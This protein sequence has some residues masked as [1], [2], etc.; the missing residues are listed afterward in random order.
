MLRRLV[1]VSAFAALALPGTAAA[2]D[3][4]SICERAQHPRVGAW[5]E[6]KMIGG[7]NDGGTMRMSVVGSE[8]RGGTEYYWLEMVMRGFFNGRGEEASGPQRMISKMLVAGLGP[9]MG[10]PMATVVKVGDAP[11]MEMP[12]GRPSP[13]AQTHTGLEDCRDAKV[14]GWERVTVPGGT[15]R[16]LHVQGASAHADTWVD[17]DLPFALVKEVSNDQEDRGQMVLTGHGMGARSQITEK[18]RPFDPQLMMQMLGGG[19]R[20][21]P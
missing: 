9:G 14:I 21:R 16:A 4:M 1:A 15:F 3:L 7:R 11:A 8:R 10:R 6:F 20:R 19:A 18:P 13:G 12:T 2:Q 17:P 5:S